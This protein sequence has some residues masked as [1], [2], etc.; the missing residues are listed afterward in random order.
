MEKPTIDK[1]VESMPPASSTQAASG[2]MERQMRKAQDWNIPYF[3]YITNLNDDVTEALYEVENKSDGLHYTIYQD[4][5]GTNVDLIKSKRT[6]DKDDLQIEDVETRDT[7]AGSM[8]GIGMGNI[9]AHTKEY[10][11]YCREDNNEFEVIDVHSGNESETKVDLGIDDKW[12]VVQT[13]TLPIINNV[14]I[15]PE[16][17]I[18]DF[19][20]RIGLVDAKAIQ[21]GTKHKFEVTGFDEQLNADL[22]GVVEAILIP[23]E[24]RNSSGVPIPEH[25]TLYDKNNK[26]MSEF[27]FEAPSILNVDKSLTIYP[28]GMGIRNGYGEVF[29]DIADKKTNI[30]DQSWVFFYNKDGREQLLGRVPTRSVRGKN[31]LNNHML[32]VGVDKDEIR[33]FFSSPDKA[34]GFVD[35]FLNKVKCGKEG[36][37]SV[38]ENTYE[39][40][41]VK[42]KGRQLFVFDIIVKDKYGNEVNKNDADDHREN[43]FNCGFLNEL[44]EA[45]RQNLVTMESWTGSNSRLDI[46]IRKPKRYTKSDENEV[47]IIEMKR[48][49]FK[50]TATRQTTD[51]A[52]KTK[53]CNYI[54]GCSTNIKQK[55]ETSFANEIAAINDAEQM[56]LG[57][58]GGH[59]VDLN[60]N[61]LRFS[62]YELHY[63]NEVYTKQEE[64]VKDK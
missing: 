7:G 8:Y 54:I 35:G 33:N 36:I 14:N 37:T 53:G 20:K 52:F 17:K 25:D 2:T 39:D 34:K 44:T 59:L 29:F 57:Q 61:H 49:G 45:E 62:N 43:I 1:W 27:T 4:G 23:Y 46:K 28:I 13:F 21:K 40:N 63:R 3:E 51:Y 31:H 42:E 5:S 30:S 11:F 64:D 50:V 24:K 9:D 47:T 15:T 26:P 55:Q 38:I 60:K 6:F 19:K 10:K 48:D 12:K 58:L 41:D 18:R 56:R 22:S 32:E 16:D